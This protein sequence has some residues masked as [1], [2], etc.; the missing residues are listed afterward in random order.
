MLPPLLGW[1][2]SLLAING[3]ETHRHKADDSANNI[4]DNAA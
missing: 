2:W 3:L 4:H 1:G